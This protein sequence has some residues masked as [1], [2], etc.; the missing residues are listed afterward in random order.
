MEAM[1]YGVIM[2]VSAGMI[3][4]VM[5]AAWRIGIRLGRADVVD[6][7]WGL[8]FVAVAWIVRASADGSPARQDLLVALTTIWGVRLAAYLAWRMR[9]TPEDRRYAAMRRRL[10]DRF[11]QVSLVS[12][13]LFQG[14]LMWVVSLPIQIGQVAETPEKI[15]VA[16]VFGVALFGVGMFFEA[17][18]DWQLARFK[19]KPWNAGR[20]LDTGLWRYTRHPNYFGD[21]CVWWGI[22]FVAAATGP[23]TASLPSPVLMT[24]LL[25]KVSGVPLTERHLERRPGYA[26]YVART[27]TFFPGPPAGEPEHEWG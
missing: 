11:D 13:F 3:L 16:G 20:V 19:A 26:D 17:V 15:G 5:L 7:A 9:R 1:A 21:F 22:F 27:N 14:A 6:V 25:M 10:G 18:G 4:A 8:G 2:L 24:V 23:G 12:V